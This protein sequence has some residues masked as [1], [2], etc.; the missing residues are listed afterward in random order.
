MFQGG[1]LGLD[2]IGVFDRSAPL[3]TGG[4]IEQ[5]D[6]TGWMGMYC[7]NLLAIAL[8]LAHEDPAYED[9]ASKFWEHFLYIANAINHLGENGTGMWDEKTD[10]S[11][12]CCICPTGTQALAHSLHGR[13]DPAVRGGD[14]GA[15]DCRSFFPG[16]SEGMQWFLENRHDLTCNVACMIAGMAE[17]GCFRSLEQINFVESCGSCWMN[18]SFSLP[19]AFGRSRAFIRTIHS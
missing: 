7:L 8:E 2:N 14:A 10:S 17:R 1:F 13:P 5:A 3:P 16:S 18:R 19:T 12:T 4:H 9:V 6:G 15:R 11:T